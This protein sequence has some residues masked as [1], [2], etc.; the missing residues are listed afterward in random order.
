MANIISF[1]DILNCTRRAIE[2]HY[3]FNTVLEEWDA[4]RKYSTWKS[5]YEP[6]ITDPLQLTALLV[7]IG[8]RDD[9][10]YII[11]ISATKLAFDK[12]AEFNS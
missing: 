4:V 11:V 3:P 8:V 6:I 2:I 1:E 7:R 9:K 10:E 5:N 12:A